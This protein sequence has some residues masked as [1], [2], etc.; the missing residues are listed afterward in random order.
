MSFIVETKS[1]SY[2]FGKSKALNSIDLKVPAQSIYGFLGPNGA[3][4]TTTLR[5]VLGLLRTSHGEVHLFGEPLWEKRKSNLKKIGSLIEQPSLYQHLTGKENLKI[6]CLAYQC[7][8]KQIETTLTFTGLLKAQNKKVKE[9]SLGMKQR[10]AIAI[11]LLHNPQLLVLDEPTN[12]LDPEGI[13]EMRSLLKTLH[14]EGKTIIISSHLLSEV[15]KIAT[16]TGIIHKGEILYQGTLYDLQTRKNG[17]LTIELEVDDIGKTK[18]L[19]DNR[20]EHSS[21]ANG[22]HISVTDKKEIAML[23]ASL[24]NAGV[25]VYKIQPIESDLESIFLQTIVKP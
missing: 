22:F 18:L 1:L 21:N 12:G 17:K 13:I 9:Y 25:Q 20:F 11:A 14:R 10:L 16:H 24:I 23:N 3:G 19:I 15:E 8:F 6:F 5:L 7:P 2:S 4:K